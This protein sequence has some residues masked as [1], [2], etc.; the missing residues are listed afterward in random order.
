MSSAGLKPYMVDGGFAL[1]PK[2]ERT[3][4]FNIIFYLKKKIIK[5]SIFEKSGLG[6]KI[7]SQKYFRIVCISW[8]NKNHTQVLILHPSKMTPT[9]KFFVILFIF[10][11]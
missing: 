11:S 7:F 2:S 3:A 4:R 5:N 9:K 6:P 1:A 10:M 8:T